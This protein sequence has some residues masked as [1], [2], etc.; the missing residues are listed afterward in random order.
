MNKVMTA[1][2]AIAGIQDGATIMIG[3]FG[4]FGAPHDVIEALVE[5]GVK[6]L[7]VICNDAGT[8]NYGTGRLIN[9]KQISK[10]IV[11]IIGPNPEAT[12]Q[13]LDGVV[14]VTLFPQG[15]LAEKIRAGGFGLGGILTKAGLGTEVE[16]GKQKVVVQGQEYLLEEPLK[17]QFALIFASK[18]DKAGNCVYMGSSH[19]H[20]P[21]MAAAAEY[22]ILEVDELVEVGEIE[23]QAI[24]TQCVMVD[25]I[26]VSKG[27]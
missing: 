23:P 10:L 1:K 18:A 20:S 12:Q 6:D 7:T 8:F 3:G 13:Q 5:K 14:D 11:S 27:E 9:T 21:S 24:H 4:G 15:S 22:T 17:A 26:V 25:A 19:A 16:K 2:E